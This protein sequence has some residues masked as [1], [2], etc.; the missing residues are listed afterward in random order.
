MAAKRGLHVVISILQQEL[1]KELQIQPPFPPFRHRDGKNQ[2]TYPE[3]KL[4]EPKSLQCRGQH[5][6]PPLLL[7]STAGQEGS[8]RTQYAAA[9]LPLASTAGQEEHHATA[10]AHHKTAE[11]GLIYGVAGWPSRRLR[12]QPPEHHVEEESHQ[13]APD[14]T[15]EIQ[16]H[17]PGMPPNTGISPTTNISP[18]DTTTPTRTKAIYNSSAS[19]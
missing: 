19:P 3:P 4:A 16:R 18:T 2:R 13:A 17:P 12:L 15:K 9:L 8:V 5:G 6:E 14:L 1:L 11:E 7:A 10:P